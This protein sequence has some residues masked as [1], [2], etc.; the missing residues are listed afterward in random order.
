MSEF[1]VPSVSFWNFS[2]ALYEKPGCA[3]H[4]LAL[5]DHWGLDVNIILFCIWYGQLKGHMPQP[6]IA[7]ALTFSQQWRS[8]VVQVLRD[9]RISM[10]ENSTLADQFADN[11]FENF[12][13]A[14]KKLELAAEQK[15]QEQL[16]RMAENHA[17]DNRVGNDTALSNLSKMCSQLRISAA[18]DPTEH[19][20]AL[21]AFTAPARS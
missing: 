6:L 8:Q 3:R 13:E 16:Q 14:V 4:C 19:F 18:S 7:E 5:Q 21:I 2:L 17:P 9:L 15:Q 1:V 10:K 11:Q 20:A 12:R